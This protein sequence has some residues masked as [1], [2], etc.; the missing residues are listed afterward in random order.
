MERGGIPVRHDATNFRDFALMSHTPPVATPSS[1]G[2]FQA[3]RGRAGSFGG[4]ARSGSYSAEL[5][6]SLSNRLRSASELEQVR[7]VSRGGGAETSSGV[8]DSTHTVL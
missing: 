2:Q 5:S 4:R 7:N 1:Y 3:K 8:H 6:S